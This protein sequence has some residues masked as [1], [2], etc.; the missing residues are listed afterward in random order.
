M[1]CTVDGCDKDRR[2][3]TATL[4]GMHAI[5]VR[6]H[7]STDEPPRRVRGAC[8]L[9]GCDR[10]HVAHGYCAP[11]YRRFK[12]NGDPGPVAVKAYDK[13][14]TRY[15][16]EGGYVRIKFDHP[17]ASKGWV[18]E[19]IVVMECVLGRALLPGEEV[20]HVNGVRGDNRPENLEL[21]VVSQPK[22]QRPSD[23]VAW[24]YEILARYGDQ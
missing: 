3:G 13:N 23:L 6:R 16:V 24:A 15:V 7:G 22:G 8:S 1:T 19:H 14:A 18:L 12:A 4:C 21:W 9:D 2:S 11:H 20:H 10:P 5:R 17:R